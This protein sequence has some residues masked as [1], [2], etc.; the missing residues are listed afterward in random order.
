MKFTAGHVV[1]EPR[2]DLIGAGLIAIVATMFACGFAFATDKPVATKKGD[3]P[4][5]DS[6]AK[7]GPSGN[8][9]FGEAAPMTPAQQRKFLL[10]WPEMPQAEIDTLTA[11]MKAREPKGAILVVCK[12]PMCEDLALNI[13]NAFES[14]KWKSNVMIG[15]QFGVPE[16]VTASDRW[17]ADLFNHAT[18]GRYAVTVESE[19]SAPG[20]YLLIGPKA[21]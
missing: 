20:V 14:A 6:P 3:R 19:R 13:D 1:F 15:T 11:A 2:V 21:R 16:G 9:G 4:P 8:I 18:N 7:V 5:I 17:L 12:D 10:K